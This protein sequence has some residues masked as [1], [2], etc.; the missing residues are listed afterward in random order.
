MNKPNI[1]SGRNLATMTSPTWSEEPVIE[2]TSQLI[3]RLY[4]ESPK[5][6]LARAS[7]R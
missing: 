6:E 3:A 7:H 1:I 4:K 5:M 2:Y